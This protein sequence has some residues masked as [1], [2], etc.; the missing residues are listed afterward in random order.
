MT[1]LTSKAILGFPKYVVVFKII[2]PPEFVGLGLRFMY[3]DSSRV[4][5]KALQDY[6]SSGIVIEIVC[7]NLEENNESTDICS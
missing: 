1:T 4:I 2:S 7:S 6:D 5:R 3:S